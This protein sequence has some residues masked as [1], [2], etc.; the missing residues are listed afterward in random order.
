MKKFY[1]LLLLVPVIF[2]PSTIFAQLTVT[3]AADNATICLGSSTGISASATPLSYTIASIAHNPIPSPETDFLVFDGTAQVPQSYGVNMDEAIWNNL[4][5]PFA[6]RYY[7]VS[8]NA[9]QVS[10]NGWIAMA[11]SNTAPGGVGVTLPNAA[12]PNNAIHAITADLDFSGIGNIGF[13]DYFV[14]GTA[15]NRKFVVEYVDVK[16]FNTTGTATVQVILSETSNIIEIHTSA[17]TNTNRG[18]A[19]GVEN[20]NG[21]VAAVVSGRN[22]STSWTGVPNA[23]RFT[24]DVINF[25]WSPATGLNTTTGPNVIASP[26]V[27]TTYTVNA[28]NASNGQTGSQTVA[29]S[30]NSASYTLA[31]T[32]GGASICQNIS[33]TPGGTYYRDGNCNLIAYV[34]PAGGNPVSNSIN[35]CMQLDT[36]ATKRGTTDLYAARKYDLEPILNPVA[37]TANI[38]LYYTQAEFNNFNTKA[39][40]SGHRAL[41]T[42]PADAMGISNL[43]LRQFHGTGTQPGNY[44]GSTEDFTTSNVNF[45]VNW[46]ATR[47]WWELTIPVN[48]FSGFYLTSKK[49]ATLAIGL[50]YFRGVQTDKQHALQWKVNCTS[51]QVKFEIERSAN[52]QQYT[53]IRQLTATQAECSQA[54]NYTDAQPLPGANYYRIK[55][56]DGDGKVAYTN[57][58][59]LTLKTSRFEMLGVYP[60]LVRNENA[61]LKL[62]AEEKT[63]MT[64]QVT[65]LSGRVMSRTVV[66][67]QAG[68]NQFLLPTSNLAAGAYFVTAFLPSEKAQTVRLVKQ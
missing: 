27:N 32:A 1:L 24:P 36:G 61:I 39:F 56:T 6:F 8:Y 47:N 35:T 28:V 42:G 66:K 9:I 11:G 12:A 64:I 38:T 58:V 7:G 49:A 25:T 18:K 41:P 53:A 67:V 63:M 51:A 17:C 65:D 29:I 44:T 68:Q 13:I 37:S 22:N 59:L 34:V 40:D 15:P 20:A 3:A 2:F 4:A 43:V 60:N 33:V 45:I 5:L 30:I 57:V 23:Y 21:T 52:G 50:D 10:T 55:M 31:G 48:G 14:S 19:Q 16:F 54:F 26:T 62:N 46:N